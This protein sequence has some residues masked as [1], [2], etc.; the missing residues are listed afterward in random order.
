MRD[1]RLNEKRCFK[2]VAC[3]LLVY[4]HLLIRKKIEIT[5]FPYVS[6]NI[7]QL[8]MKNEKK[9]RTFVKKRKIFSCQAPFTKHFV[10]YFNPQ[11][12]KSSYSWD[13]I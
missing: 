3:L 5:L 12:P 10:I 11:K 13:V 8:S 1:K 4:L 6:K 7:L 9:R 2:L